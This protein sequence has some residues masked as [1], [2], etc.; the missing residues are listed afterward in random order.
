MKA[1]ANKGNTTLLDKI[2]LV[3]YSTWAV[4]FILVPL[5]FVA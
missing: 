1:R 4:I 2:L 5:A 3:P